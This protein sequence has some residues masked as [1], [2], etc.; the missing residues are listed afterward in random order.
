M[1][2]IFADSGERYCKIIGNLTELAKNNPDALKVLD[3]VVK[4]LREATDVGMGLAGDLRRF[5]PFGSAIPE[6]GRFEIGLAKVKGRISE[7]DALAQSGA[8]RQNANKPEHDAQQAPFI[9]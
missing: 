8:F 2:I 1:T 3:V 4:L 5:S 7:Y 6:L 9:R